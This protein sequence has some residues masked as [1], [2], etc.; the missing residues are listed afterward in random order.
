MRAFE[1]VMHDDW[2]LVTG[3]AVQEAAGQQ[4]YGDL[5]G[6]DVPSVAATLLLPRQPSPAFKVHIES[7]IT[8]HACHTTFSAAFTVF[9]T[10]SAT[11]YIECSNCRAQIKFGA[12]GVDALEGSLVEFN[13]QDGHWITVEPA[14]APAGATLSPISMT[15]KEVTADK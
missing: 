7:Q 14:T 8:C 15:V 3:A 5:S 11:G 2:I 6:L 13:G 12:W 9:R 1:T 10:G 4:L